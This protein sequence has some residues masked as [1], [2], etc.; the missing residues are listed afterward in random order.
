MSANRPNLFEFLDYRVFLKSFAEFLAVEKDLSQRALG[1]ILG[2]SSPNYL[3]TL[4]SGKRSLSARMAKQI[5]RRLGLSDIETRFFI[6]LVLFNDCTNPEQKNKIYSQLLK[7][8]K[9]L[10]AYRTAAAEYEFFSNWKIVAL[11]EALGTSWRSS[12]V[13]QMA[14]D[15]GIS[16]DEVR[17]A[18]KVLQDLNL[19][20]KTP[21]GWTR[22]SQVLETPPETQSLNIRNFHRQMIQKASESVD[23]YGSQDRTLSGL[24]M[25][26]S[27]ERIEELKARVLEF[28]REINSEFSNDED[29][30]RV[31]QLS[32]QLFPL[33]SIR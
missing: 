21:T 7:S 12:S 26:L 33:F 16:T 10:S 25:A 18:L 8:K 14:K 24:T 4:V 22:R 29:P 20:E 31:V 30:A 6:Q 1:K 15:M 28:Q 32:F 5:A 11:L 23:R 13:A 9:F 3:Q 27:L 19:I 2:F 17:E